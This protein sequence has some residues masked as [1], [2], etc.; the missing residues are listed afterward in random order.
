LCGAAD[1]KVAAPAPR[2]TLGSLLQAPT[3][4]DATWEALRGNVVVLE[5]WATWCGGC[6]EQIPHLNRLEEQF[7]NH[8]VRF[9]SLTD[10]EPG[11]VQRFLKDYPISGW[12]GLDSNAQTF[13]RYGI[14][15]RP[16][17]VVVDAAGVVRG[18]GNPSDL[19]GEIM[20]NLL[21]GKPVVFSRE[22]GVAKLQALPEPLYQAMVRP[23]GPV[24]VTGYSS[25]AISGKAGKRWETWGVRLRR[26]L[27]DAYGVP[28][29]RIDG[30]AWASSVGYDVALAAPNLN[31]ARRLALLRRT[32]EDTF[33]L[34][35]HKESRESD[36]YV[37]RIGGGTQPKLRPAGTG[38][39][40]QWG[41]DGDVTA[42]SRP[43]AS[44]ASDAGRV[45][46]K[47]VL[48]ETGLAGR[49]DFELKWDA[50]NPPSMIE[51]V[52]TQLGLELTP[53]RRPLEYLVVDSA[54]Q[55][56]AW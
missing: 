20:E 15:G 48:D 11:F 53:S 19:T 10:E 36:V 55:P 49:F 13:G 31:D 38:A 4:T 32:M 18:I 34:K 1:L 43:L 5:F 8:P 3:G 54:V 28:E 2:L 23:A 35:V 45:L 14:D 41:K 25:G 46:G 26:L 39:S 24:G 17:T 37:L 9:I 51:A 44:I 16:T 7:R 52:R 12:I 56:Q 33:Q 27:S 6:R 50:A 21:A 42:V 30:P 47:T 22:A 29:S 40:S